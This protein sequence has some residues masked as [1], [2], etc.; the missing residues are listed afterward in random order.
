VPSGLSK[1]TFLPRYLK[2]SSVFASM[3][4]PEHSMPG[5]MGVLMGWETL[6]RS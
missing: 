6:E 3:T 2:G 4:I 1:A 5:T